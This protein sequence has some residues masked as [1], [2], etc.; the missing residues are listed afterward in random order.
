MIDGLSI[1]VLEC[2][3]GHLF[4]VCPTI[5]LLPVPL[6]DCYWETDDPAM[7]LTVRGTPT[8]ALA[9]LAEKVCEIHHM[10]L[11]IGPTWNVDPRAYRAFRNRFVARF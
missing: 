8:D 4:S 2:S 3:A 11:R 10:Y 7:R 5:L 6:T 9:Q 1:A